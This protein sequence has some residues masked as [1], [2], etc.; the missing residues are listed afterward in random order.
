MNFDAPFWHSP[1][2]IPALIWSLIWKGFALWRAGIT[3]D[4]WWFL[5]LFV[6]NT[7]GILDIFYLLVFSRR[8][9]GEPG[10]ADLPPRQ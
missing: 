8:E 6:L 9:R 3:R 4:K 1:W 5:A 2:L 10:T 7:F